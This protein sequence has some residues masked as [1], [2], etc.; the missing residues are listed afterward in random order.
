VEFILNQHR[1]ENRKPEIMLYLQYIYI[2]L[3]PKIVDELNIVVMAGS[4][5]KLA[6]ASLKNRGHMLSAKKRQGS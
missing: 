3:R 1:R 6:Y 2:T 4:V 5:S